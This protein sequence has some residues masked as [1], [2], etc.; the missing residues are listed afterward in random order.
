MLCASIFLPPTHYTDNL[1][2]WVVLFILTIEY[3]W[4]SLNC[5]KIVQIIAEKRKSSIEALNRLPG[6]SQ[7]P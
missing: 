4:M 2:F 3:F 5:Q 7:N 6:L 1:S